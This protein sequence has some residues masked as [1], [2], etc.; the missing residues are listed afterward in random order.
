MFHATINKRKV[1][2]LHKQKI[3]IFAWTVNSM[4]EKEKL[5]QMNIDGIITDF[6]SILK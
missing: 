1:N 3:K 5:I 2:S 6:P 4:K